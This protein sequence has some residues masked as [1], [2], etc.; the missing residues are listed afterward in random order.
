MLLWQPRHTQPHTS[1]LC[2]SLG[3]AVGPGIGGGLVPAVAAPEH[4]TGSSSLLPRS[5]LLASMPHGPTGNT[6][7][8][9]PTSPPCKSPGKLAQQP[10]PATSITPHPRTSYHYHELETQGCSG[11]RA[12]ETGAFRSGS[13]FGHC[14][15]VVLLKGKPQC[16]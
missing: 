12:G 11:H 10:G 5:P 9:H 6:C 16:Y 1:S 14:C 3:Q 7:P 15:L 4:T 13:G 8:G 2:H